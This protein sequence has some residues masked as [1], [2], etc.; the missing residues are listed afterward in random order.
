M[1]E[2]ALQNSRIRSVDILRGIVMVIMALDHTRDF[3]SNF[4]HN[5]TDLEYTT[6]GMFFTRWITHYCAPVFI[7]LAGT[8]AYLS[9]S[10][11]NDKNSAALFLLKRGIWLIILEITIVRFGWMF[12]LDYAHVVMQVIWAIGWSMI[13]LAGLIYLP[14]YAILSIG[15]LMIFGHNAL[16]GVQAETM[17]SGGFLWNV[18]HD[19]DIV[20]SGDN[21]FY[22][23][24]SLIPW[25]GVMATGY[26]F[27]KLLQRPDRNKRLYITGISAIVLFIALRASNIYGDPYPWAVQETAV[28]TLLSFL[29]C[30]KYPPSLLYLCM[31]LGPAILLMPLLDKMDNA[32][33]RFFKV[34]GAVP[35]FYYILHIY[36]IH[37]MAL[38]LGLMLGLPSN[39][40]TDSGMMFTGRPGWGYGL[41]GVYLAWVIA[42]LL[43][44]F[45]S[46]WFM[47]VKQQHKKWWL[48]YI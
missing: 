21:N 27:G 15:L 26:C 19:P 22:V 7:F 41:P 44:Y 2:Q 10:K 38:A 32:V 35:M 47:K 18:L 39:Y 36:L 11:K 42:V 4:T 23:F 43:L 3:F 46:R 6:T 30:N 40:F 48:S 5:P 12:N 33:G 9:L 13:F 8:S 37:G 34:F 16:D 17:G 25:I 20:K 31:T 24:Y 1:Q 45:P 28:K 29:N 14:F